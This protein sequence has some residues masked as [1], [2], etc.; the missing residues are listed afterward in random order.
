MIYVSRKA[1][2]EKVPE[3]LKFSLAY[4][5]PPTVPCSQ[6]AAFDI[7]YDDAPCD[8]HRQIRNVVYT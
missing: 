1:R 6:F 8:I 5:K 7:K 4:T 2:P 3:R